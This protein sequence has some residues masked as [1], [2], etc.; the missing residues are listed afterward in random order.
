M[1]SGPPPP[2][3]PPPPGMMSG[4][5]PPPPPPG[6]MGG[7]PP[8]PPP[9]GMMGGAPPPPMMAAAVKTAKYVGKPKIA[10]KPLHW[11]KIAPMAVDKTLWKSISDHNVELEI[12]SLD[13]QFRSK[14]PA[15]PVISPQREA[16]KKVQVVSLL[17]SK[18][19]NNANIVIQHI[20]LD[21]KIIK[22]SLIFMQEGLLH[23]ENIKGLL[24]INPTAEESKLLTSYDGP[25]ENL[26]KAEQFLLE[27]ISI[28]Y[29]TLRLNA[30]YFRLTAP[31]KISELRK[32]VDTIT[33]ACA[34]S[35]GSR[36]LK[37][38]LEY[39]LAIGNYMNGGS[40]R[41]NCFGFRITFI[42]ELSKIK[43]TDTK[44]NLLSYI[45]SMIFKEMIDSNTYPSS[46]LNQ[47]NKQLLHIP[48]ASKISLSQL[49]TD[50]AAFQKQVQ[51]MRTRVEELKDGKM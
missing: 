34:E 27:M 5:P 16:T 25:K 49:Q 12:T 19:S 9:P 50:V 4:P 21:V 33:K 38:I 39:T 32:S 35:K 20:K 15:T 14:A 36:Q 8:P 7:P 41:G 28:P 30:Y 29:V 37:R 44:S 45:A 48:L 31:S 17:D 51:D 22:D 42:G 23:E 13:S 11:T 1:M 43:S 40:N 10:M 18:R 47:L 3:P 6:M 24:D 26:G 46:S 2:P